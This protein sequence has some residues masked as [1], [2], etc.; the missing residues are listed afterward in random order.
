MKKLHNAHAEAVSAI[1]VVTPIQKIVNNDHLILQEKM[2]QIVDVMCQLTQAS[3]CRLYIWHGSLALEFCSAQFQRNMAPSSVTDMLVERIVYEVAH[4]NQP[5][6]LKDLSQHPTCRLNPQ[7]YAMLPKGGVLVFPIGTESDVK[8]IIA[9]SA[10]ETD[11]FEILS[12]QLRAVAEM[13]HNLMRQSPQQLIPEALRDSDAYLPKIVTGIPIHNGLAKGYALIHDQRTTVTK[14]YADD[15]DQEVPRLEQAIINM[16][17]HLDGLVKQTPFAAESEEATILET[18]QMI[19]HDR[20]WLN[21]IRQ[22][23]KEGLTAEA[24][25]QRVL[26][27]LKTRMTHAQ[28]F[29]LQ[30]RIWDIEDVS[31]RLMNHLGGQK[32]PI[33]TQ[34][35]E[36]VILLARS[37]GPA[38]LLDYQRLNVKA[39]LL[40]EAFQTAH[41]A[42]VA[43]AL[44]IPVI[45]QV[46]D[47]LARIKPGD[48]LLVDGREGRITLR[49]NS[50]ALYK[51]DQECQRR[52]YKIIE[53]QRHQPL[54]AI[55][56]DGVPISIQLNACV[57]ND[58]DNLSGIAV[59]GV[60]LFR[61]EILF[62]TQKSFP[63]VALQTKLY[64]EILSRA[65]NLPVIF[66]TLDIG[67]DKILPY[68]RHFHEE[69]PMMGW[70]AIRIGLERPSIL[71]QQLRAMIRAASGL[72]LHIMFPMIAD[73]QEFLAA[74]RILLTELDH[75]KQLGYIPPLDVHIG[76]TLEVPSLAW[77]IDNLAPHVDFI[78]IGTNDLFQFFFAAD[79]GN[80]YVAD[81]Y[82]NLSPSFL[83]FLKF[84]ATKM[85]QAQKPTTVCG[86]MAGNPLE[87]MAL[88][89]L[90]FRTLSLARSAV[91]PVKMMI[92]SLNLQKLTHFI[93]SQLLTSKKTIRND[94]KLFTKDHSIAI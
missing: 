11:Q 25:I 73:E 71:R 22:A 79:R 2:H 10:T 24:A 92:R 6:I 88:L 58:M 20:G 52:S 85:I 87:A 3:L 93:E 39:L 23:V 65:Q 8:G 89:A 7:H 67:G 46:R 38:D 37:L 16:H 76:A 4:L 77:R 86:E 59:D 15:I 5:V 41:V 64:R 70:R 28:D 36:P 90:G 60:G 78:S 12:P 14:V 40:E 61:T 49:P 47:L 91:G 72:S 81:R 19:A 55:T 48:F 44:N 75:C 50:L 51:F 17:T 9:L 18:F 57:L 66:R 69:N 27:H 32:I 13:L 82:D 26:Q 56:R 42:I 45:G 62:M 54:Q 84:I 80:P 68:L 94:L 74:K 53:A 1:D 43:R 33:G 34:D 21:Q 83:S 30:D 29:Y 63:D 31:N 35:N